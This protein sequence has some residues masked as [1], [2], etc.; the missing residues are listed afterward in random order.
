MSCR[1]I[2][3]KWTKSVSSSNI[4]KNTTAYLSTNDRILNILLLYIAKR[5]C[6]F[7]THR[8][9]NAFR[10]ESIVSK[11]MGWLKGVFI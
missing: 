11:R 10:I 7:I 6:I 4:I 2:V 3:P 1:P 5:E 8:P 9:I